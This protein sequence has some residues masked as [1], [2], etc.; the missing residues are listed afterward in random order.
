MMTPLL[1]SLTRLTSTREQ[2]CAVCGAD[3]VP[4]EDSGSRLLSLVAADQE[5]F[6]VLMCGGCHSKWSH[7]VTITARTRSESP[8]VPVLR[9]PS[10]G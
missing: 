6:S 4:M 3:F 5:P 2:A 7:G 9:Q 10:R 8:A 1:L